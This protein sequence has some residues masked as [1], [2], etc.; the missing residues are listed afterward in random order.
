MKQIRNLSRDKILTCAIT[1]VE[2]YGL[3][4]LSMRKIAK[5]LKFQV[6]ALYNHFASKEEL[7]IALQGYYLASD[8]SL[9]N[10]NFAATSWKEFLT[11]IAIVTR[12]AFLAKP[13]VLELFATYSSDSKESMLHFEKYLTKMLE[14]GFTIKD[15]AQISQ[16]IYTYICGYTNFEIGIRKNT[17][18]TAVDT[19]FIYS[20]Q[21][22]N[23]YITPLAY[24]FHN[25]FGWDLEQDF[26][27]G[28]KSLINGFSTC[29]TGL[30][31]KVRKLDE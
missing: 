26:N 3:E 31:N 30:N 20:Q 25:Q 5:N 14:F 10:I 8:S 9:F 11:S 28:I 16:T 29:L 23:K 15:A 2:E 13:F 12:E 21:H 7:I 19:K 24:Q 1:H 17:K 6:S 22:A 27:F 4:N 18:N